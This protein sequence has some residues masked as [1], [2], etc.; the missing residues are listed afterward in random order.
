VQEGW[1]Y[2]HTR[3]DEDKRHPCIIPY[4]RLSEGER[5]Y[6]R[7]TVRN[8]LKLIQKLGYKIEKR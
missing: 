4:E 6:D 1:Q 2:G 8:T 5:D 7:N 3:N